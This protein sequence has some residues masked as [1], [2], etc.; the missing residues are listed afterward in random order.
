MMSTTP[1]GLELRPLS[2]P[3]TV[4]APNAADFVEMTHVRNRIYREIAGHDDE[5]ISPAELLPAYAPSPHEI[6]LVWL[7]VLDGRIV[8]RVGL[9]IPQEPG[10][11]VAFARI[12]L[13]RE[14]WGRGIGSV[15]YRL[16]EDT[17]RAHART[18]VQAWVE[19]PSADGPR[20]E[21]PTGFGSIPD[22]RAARFARGN[23]FTLEQVE[24]ISAL[25]LAADDSRVDAL[26]ARARIAAAGYRIVQWELP[27]PDEFVDGYAAMKARM[28]TDA[29]AA[30]LVFDEE[31]W[32]A[33]RIRRHE[34]IYLDAGRTMLVTAAQHAETGD[35][36]A[37]NELVVGADRT[38]ATHQEDTLVR[39][40]HRGHRLGMLVKCAALVAWRDIAPASP[41]VITYSAEENRPML[42]INEAIGFAPIAY[43]GA[44][45]KVLS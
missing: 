9:D 29:P 32:D 19:H 16:L 12:E 18:I 17:V 39:A 13:L 33:E 4:D 35:L 42:D 34:S 37:F 41:R 10:S 15:A 31:T 14:V 1:A 8:G 22:D 25:D 45:K 28:V 20:L 23:G 40:D 3:A 44:W 36:V 21:P 7:P 26:L 6:R 38:E 5:R 30:A 2:I 11:S 24:R 27:T 43:E